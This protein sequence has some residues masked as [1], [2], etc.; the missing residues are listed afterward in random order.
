MFFETDVETRELPQVSWSLAILECPETPTLWEAFSYSLSVTSLTDN[1][2]TVW[3]YNVKGYV[4][5]SVSWM[6]VQAGKIS[7][8]NKSAGCN[9]SVHVEILGISLVWILLK[10]SKFNKRAGWNKCMKVGKFVKFKKDCCTII[11][12]NKVCSR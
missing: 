6:I 8:K 10:M 9:N 1:C 3:I 4:S 5:T 7:K 11:R 12:E 2:L